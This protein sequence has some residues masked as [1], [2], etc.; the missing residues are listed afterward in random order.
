MALSAHPFR[1]VLN[2]SQSV[3][4]TSRVLVYYSAIDPAT[5]STETNRS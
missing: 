4:L 3:I 1:S 2:A 5:S